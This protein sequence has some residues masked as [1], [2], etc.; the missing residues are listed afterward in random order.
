MHLT[1]FHLVRYLADL[2]TAPPQTYYALLRCTAAGQPQSLT[3]HPASPAASQSSTYWRPASSGEGRRE[4][5]LGLFDLARARLLLQAYAV[6]IPE[7]VSVF[8]GVAYRLDGSAEAEA[9]NARHAYAPLLQLACPEELGAPSASATGLDWRNLDPGKEIV[10][11]NRYV[12]LLAAKELRDNRRWIQADVSRTTGIA[13][14]ALRSW[15][16]QTVTIYNR[17]LLDVLCTFLDCEVGELLYLA[18][19][20]P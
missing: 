2:R 1:F 18:E 19:V 4:L 16:A 3:F 7:Q 15:A 20:D 10:V 17:R 8:C 11:R 6:Q 9:H 14:A 13:S 5:Y 12:E